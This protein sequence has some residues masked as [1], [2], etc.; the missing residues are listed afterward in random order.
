MLFRSKTEKARKE[1][2][3]EILPGEKEQE[4][5]H[6]QEQRPVQENGDNP[7]KL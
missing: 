1:N 3:N 5:E 6:E 7:E 2:N 4:Q